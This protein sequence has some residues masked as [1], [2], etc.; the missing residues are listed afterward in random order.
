MRWSEAFAQ[1]L[2]GFYCW[3]FS[4]QLW[5]NC[6]ITSLKWEIIGSKSSVLGSM[7]V[8]RRVHT[9]TDKQT[10]LLESID[11]WKQNRLAEASFPKYVVSPC[12]LSFVK[13][14]KIWKNERFY[15]LLPAA[16]GVSDFRVWGDYLLTPGRGTAWSGR[17][18]REGSNGRKCDTSGSS[19]YDC[20]SSCCNQPRA[21]GNSVN[22]MVIYIYAPEEVWNNTIWQKTQLSIW[23]VWCFV[24]FQ[25]N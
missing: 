22:N 2:I 13:W 25:K 14:L 1:E 21:I 12:F 9:I 11:W 7:L 6:I 10:H 15:L 23:S 18:P 20:Q 5:D 17:N 8:F 4:T 16:I 24:Y 19:I 3:I